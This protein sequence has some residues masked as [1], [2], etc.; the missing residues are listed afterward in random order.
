MAALVPQLPAGAEKVPAPGPVLV[1]GVR[2]GEEPLRVRPAAR[3][4]L[5]QYPIVTFQYS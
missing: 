4:H 3:P 2:E 5:G 1:A